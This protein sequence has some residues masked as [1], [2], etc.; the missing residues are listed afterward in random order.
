M[1]TLYW[2]LTD[3]WPV[4]SWSSVDFFGRWKPLHFE[5]KTQF[6]PQKIS[7]LIDG[8]QL[9]IYLISDKKIMPGTEAQWRFD[10]TDFDGNIQD[11]LSGLKS[12]R[13]ELSQLIWKGSIANWKLQCRST[14]INAQIQF[15]DEKLNLTIDLAKPKDQQLA[16]AQVEVNSRQM[17]SGDIELSFLASNYIRNL[18]IEQNIDG[19]FS[20]NNFDLIPREL[21]V[22]MFTP[23]KE[24]TVLPAFTFR[25]LN[26]ILAD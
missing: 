6:E 4:A 23:N 9:S 18:W 25:T 3:C 12:I 13:N 17:R 15:G 8:D 20:D 2:Q 11:S 24:S 19:H 14:F 16:A 21:K 22:V 26:D 5:A 1:G 10:L 7:H